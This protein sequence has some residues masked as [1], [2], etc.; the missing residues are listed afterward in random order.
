MSNKKKINILIE[1]LSIFIISLIF[2]MI[3]HELNNDNVWN[4]GF[5]Y[6]IASGLIP[7]RDFNMVTTPLFPLLESM[8]FH[9]I[10]KNI[11]THYII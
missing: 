2:S 9:V 7:Y 11:V 1:L 3:F 4:Y 5:A 8:I 10:G 6:N